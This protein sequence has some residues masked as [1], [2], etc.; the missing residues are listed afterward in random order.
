MTKNFP[1]IAAFSSELSERS[2]ILFFSISFLLFVAYLLNFWNKIF[3]LS[4]W[5]NAKERVNLF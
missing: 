3:T 4:C 1:F 5:T 2:G